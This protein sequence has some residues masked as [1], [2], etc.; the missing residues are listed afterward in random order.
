MESEKSNRSS[1]KQT[2]NDGFIPPKT[3]AVS[4]KVMAQMQKM[5]Y[6]ESIENSSN[7]TNLDPVLRM[8]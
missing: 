4:N 5:N 8:R 6:Y 1:S 3:S 7:N 2:V